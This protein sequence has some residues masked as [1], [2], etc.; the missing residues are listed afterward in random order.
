MIPHCAFVFWPLSDDPQRI[1]STVD[2]IGAKSPKSFRIRYPQPEGKYY[3]SIHKF[4][5]KSLAHLHLIIIE[6]KITV[7]PISTPPSMQSS[8]LASATAMERYDSKSSIHR[9]LTSPIGRFINKYIILSHS[10]VLFLFVYFV[11]QYLVP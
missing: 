1:F 4:K 8:S 5:K 11:T 7:Q 10:I 9:P 3:T 6:C 2:L